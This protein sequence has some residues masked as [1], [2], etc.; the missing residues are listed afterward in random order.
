MK[1]YA[2]KDRLLLKVLIL[3]PIV[4]LIFYHTSKLYN[5][6]FGEELVNSTQ[7]LDSFR[8]NFP[9]TKV[10]LLQTIFRI[11]IITGLILILLKKNT[12]ILF[13]WIGVGCLVASQFFIESASTND[14]IQTIHSGIKPLK[15][16]I[17]PAFIT[18]LHKKINHTN[19]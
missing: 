12:G 13:M 9:V 5:I 2:K 19:Q 15:G 6:Y 8:S 16:V 4:F 18:Y 7:F 10:L 17:L 3:I 14:Y 11:I 1:Q